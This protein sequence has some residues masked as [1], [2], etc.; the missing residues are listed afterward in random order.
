MD[1]NGQALSDLNSAVKAA[2]GQ[3]AIAAK[4]GMSRSHLGNILAGLRPLRS[5]TAVRLRAVLPEVRAE[6]WVELLAPLSHGGEAQT[7]AEASA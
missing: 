3:T 4:L 2:G 1:A 6:V 5:D 7:E